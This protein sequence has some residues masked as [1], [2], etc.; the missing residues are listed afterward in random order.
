MAELERLIGERE[1]EQEDAG[2][3]IARVNAM[4]AAEC[5]RRR[6]D[7]EDRRAM[8]SLRL[9]AVA[10]D[11]RQL[12][13]D[14]RGDLLVLQTEKEDR[15]ALFPSGRPS[16][17]SVGTEQVGLPRRNGH[18]PQA[19]FYEKTVQNTLDP[20]VSIREGSVVVGEQTSG[21]GVS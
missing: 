4:L 7:D 5:E 8:N 18:G 1:A 15:F 13:R 20:D 9:L 14:L 11:L 3:R 12:E 21:T 17:A 19:L 2:R 16:R 6:R 10:S